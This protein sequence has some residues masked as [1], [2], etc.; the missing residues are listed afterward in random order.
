M[1]VLRRALR[2]FAFRQ[3]TASIPVA[4]MGSFRAVTRRTRQVRLMLGLGLIAAAVVAV[5]AAPAQPGRHFLP[6]K[7][8]GIVV[9]DISASITPKTYYRIEE[10]LSTLAASRDRFGLVLFSDTAYEALPPGTPP[11]ALVPFLRFFAPPTSKGAAATYLNGIPPSPWGQWFSGGT[12]MSSGLILAAQML[13]KDHTQ[14][15]SVVLISDLNDDP[16]DLTKLSNTVLYFQQAHIP[17]QIVGL[18]PTPANA[19]FFKNLLGT[20]AIFQQARLPTAAQAAGKLALLG[21]FPTVL[22]I[23]T[24]LIVFLLALNEWWSEPLRWKTRRFA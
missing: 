2:R 7:T 24:G 11:T 4:A 20:E 19:D 12:V 5:A 13:L 10:E 14:H 6:A 9:L 16:T 22:A 21:S 17:L 15:G 1:N 3:E 18:D 23:A 8:V